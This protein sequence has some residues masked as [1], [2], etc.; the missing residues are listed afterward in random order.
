[1]SKVDVSSFLDAEQALL[2]AAKGLKQIKSSSS[3]LSTA[4][5]KMTELLKACDAIVKASEVL[6]SKGAEAMG[7]ISELD[8]KGSLERLTSSVRTIERAVAQESK[9]SLQRHLDQQK[10]IQE[11]E[12]LVSSLKTHFL[13]GVGA[14]VVLVPII[15][16][17][18]LRATR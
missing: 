1:M 9:D 15:Q 4:E 6:R 12:S 11:M 2:D 17:L 13:L 16:F 3:T 18:I 14:V 10:S 8:L 7:T 5:E